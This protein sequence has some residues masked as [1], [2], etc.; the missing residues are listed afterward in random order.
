[1]LRIITLVFIQFTSILL[2]LVLRRI[3]PSFLLFEAIIL[4]VTLPFLLFLLVYRLRKIKYLFKN[5]FSNPL[6]SIML[7]SLVIFNLLFF[8]L[9]MID[10]SKSLYI[11]NWVGNGQPISRE[12]LIKK[13]GVIENSNDGKYI[14][15]RIE[16]QLSRNVISENNGLLKLTYY[17]SLLKS[18]ADF[19]AKIFLLKG[20]ES[21]NLIYK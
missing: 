17:G 19:T 3:S 10:R 5:I 7:S 18:F 4:A 2:L 6:L 1:M 15:I 11:I 21:Q 13:V 12:D 8:S 9:M 20:W 14:E 16:E